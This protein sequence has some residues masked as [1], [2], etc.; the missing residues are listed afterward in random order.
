MRQRI[1]A[2][3]LAVNP[4]RHCEKARTVC[5]WKSHY[6]AGG[7]VK[8]GEERCAFLRQPCFGC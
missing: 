8:Q 4:T 2:L 3:V 6:C 1:G 7:K 5:R